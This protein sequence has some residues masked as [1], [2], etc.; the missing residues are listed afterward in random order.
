MELNA[1]PGDP[2]ANSYMTLAEA[3]ARM[4]GYLSAELWDA[5]K[6]EGGEATG[7]TIRE[8]L[9][10][11]AARLVDRYRPT[12]PKWISTQRLMWPTEKDNP[13]GTIPDAIKDSVCEWIE[14]YLQ[15]GPRFQALKRFQAE[16]ITSM[17]QLGQS[18]S[19]EKDLSMLP[20]GARLLIDRL[21]ESYGTII[22]GGPG[23]CEPPI[24]G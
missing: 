8:R 10:M 16:G 1:I 2:E 6:S 14:A 22:V 12:P 20:G 4:D 15:G 17:S 3:D 18:S 13:A 24:Y 11:T 23:Q 19:F 7:K 21:I 5:L 9:L